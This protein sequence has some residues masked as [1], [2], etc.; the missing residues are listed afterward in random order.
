MK[1]LFSLLVTFILLH[2]FSA[3]SQLGPKDLIQLQYAAAKQNTL[4]LYLPKTYTEATPVIILLHGGAWMM[5]GN[6]YTGKTAKDLRNRGFVVAN[7]DYRYVND[8]VHGRDLLMD[9]DKAVTFIQKK[10]A[11][12]HYKPAGY[13]IAGISAG[14]HLALLYG[15]TSLKSIK[16][17][18][19]LCPPTQLDDPETLTALQKNNLVKNVELLANAAYTPGKIPNP[20][21]TTVSPYAH[22]K[23]IPTLLFHGDKDDLVPYTQSAFLYEILK[24][25]KVIS[26]FITMEGKGHDCGMNQ[27]DSEKR[28]LDEIVKWVEEYN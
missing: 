17:I 4:D 5:G 20:K 15:Y 2:T 11:E 12:Y 16:S 25:K 3:H 28:V 26:K 23:A 8:T 19:A 21:F 14:A 9:I 27:P 22:V 6:E 7:V 10:A 18:T 13:H 24:E 1:N